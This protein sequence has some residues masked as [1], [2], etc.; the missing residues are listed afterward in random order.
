MALLLFA[1]VSLLLFVFRVGYLMSTR[2]C[3]PTATLISPFMEAPFLTLQVKS[4]G[5]LENWCKLLLRVQ[6]N[7]AAKQKKSAFL[8][9]T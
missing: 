8:F 3:K 6:E 1:A 7:A 5:R 2:E 4:E 9:C